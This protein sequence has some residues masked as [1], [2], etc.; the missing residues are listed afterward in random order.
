[1][2]SSPF[3][4]DSIRQLKSETLEILA[5]HGLKLER[6]SDDRKD[7][8]IDHRYMDVLLRASEDP[9]VGIGDFASGVRAGPGARLPRLP[10]L[11][12]RKKR[13]RLPKQMDPLDYLEDHSA[14][15][16]V[17]RLNYSSLEEHSDSVLEVLVDQA[18]RGQ[19]LRLSEEEARRRYPNL[20]VASLGARKKEK[21]GGVISARVL[22]DDTHG[23][24]V[25]HRTRVRDQ[26]RAPIAADLKRIMREKSIAEQPTF[27]L[28]ADV[29]EA[30]RQ[31]PIAPQDWHLLGCQ[32]RP[33][34]EVFVNTVGTFGVASASYYWSRVA[35]AIGRLCQYIPA[36]SA[37]TW[38]LLVAD[39]YH[40]EA[41]GTEYR[42]SIISFFVL[43]AVIGVP[44]AW[45]KT[46]GG[47]TVSWVGFE[48]LH[49]S[50]KIGLSE[51]R[52]QW[53]QRWTRETADSG[54][55]HMSA[56]EEGLGR[57][58]YVASA[59]EFERPFLSPLYRFLTLHPRGSVRRLPA[60]VIFV[61]R[62][63]ADRIQES[64]HYDCGHAWTLRPAMRGQG[65]A[66]G[67][68]CWVKMEYPIRPDHVGLV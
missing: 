37:N 67:V 34:G 20:T 1:M 17:W 64:R 54:Y 29:T 22:F 56:F 27:A 46:A 2:E 38:H 57:I 44:L 65:S 45:K 15:D 18:N 40:L 49:R 68:Q 7:V 58:M 42:A 61:L 26:E 47:D 9:E 3:D 53:F 66:D 55:V 30:H 14:N 6:S 62:Y 43:C 33:G 12:A 31:V 24:A 51:K 5:E 28:S 50:Y 39:D 32:V 8:P 36:S 13:W 35:T 16:A 10:A 19:V 59:L 60:Y 21:P 63:L 25:N 41:G 52:A 11:Y 4:P 23:I 48:L